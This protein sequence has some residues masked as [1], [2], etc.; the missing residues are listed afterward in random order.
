MNRRD[1]RYYSQRCVVCDVVRT[2]HYSLGACNRFHDAKWREEIL[3]PLLDITLQVVAFLFPTDEKLARWY[4]LV[5]H[6]KEHP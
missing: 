2:E 5:R 3:A 4:S 6:R 1:A